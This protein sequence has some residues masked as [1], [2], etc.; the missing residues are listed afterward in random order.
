LL[1]AFTALTAW[2][3]SSIAQEPKENGNGHKKTIVTY[4]GKVVSLEKADPA[5][6]VVKTDKA[7]L[8]VELAPMTFLESS[9]LML[10]PDSDV[11]VR[12]YETMRDG[13]TVF[14]A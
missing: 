13:K 12:G 4:T 3:T 9:K 6:V 7:D 1:T 10:E 5:M 11:T 8:N 14:V 2:S